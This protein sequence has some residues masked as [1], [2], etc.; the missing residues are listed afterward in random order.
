MFS[1]AK[2]RIF[3]PRLAGEP[4][5]ESHPVDRLNQYRGSGPSPHSFAL[6]ARMNGAPR[7]KRLRDA[8]RTGR[9][10]SSHQGRLFWTMPRK[11]AK[12]SRPVPLRL[13]WPTKDADKMK[14]DAVDR[15]HTS[16]GTDEIG[17]EIAL[18]QHNATP[19]KAAMRPGDFSRTGRDRTALDRDRS[20]KSSPPPPAQPNH[21]S[22]IAHKLVADKRDTP[23]FTGVADFSR[24]TGLLGVPTPE[25]ARL[26]ALLDAR[27]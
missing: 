9:V 12:N 24:R 21:L 26:N 8:R 5:G 4:F 3:F 27:S 22:S 7:P 23:G 14:P 10:Q 16:K 2:S 17:Q 6:A 18:L 13:T 19:A 20:H 25:A 11:L 1:R 15:G